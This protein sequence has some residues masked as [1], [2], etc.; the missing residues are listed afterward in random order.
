M[1]IK[2]YIDFRTN[3]ILTNKLVTAC[4]G[5][6]VCC[7]TVSNPLE[8]LFQL[9]SKLQSS[10]IVWEK[11]HPSQGVYTTFTDHCYYNQD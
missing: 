1:I 9:I 6:L 3:R 7:I 4:Q 5:V 11:E 10:I 2:I 8:D